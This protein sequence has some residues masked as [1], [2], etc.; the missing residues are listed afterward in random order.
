MDNFKIIIEKIQHIKYL[1]Y[2]I[3]LTKNSIHCIVGKNGIGKTTLVKAIQNLKLADTFDKTSS[4]YIFNDNSEITYIIDSNK[5]NYSYN[6]KTNIFD[7]KDIIDKDIKDNLYVELPIPYGD[8][9]Q[10]F[11][12]CGE[13][14]AD[15]RNKIIEGKYTKPTKLIQ[16]LHNIYKDDRF[17]NLK[18]VSIKKYKYYFILLDDNYY[19]RED[20]LSSG[21]YFLINIFKLIEN[22]C[23]LILIDELDISLDASA[24]VEL[25]SQLRE[26]AIEYKVNIIFTTHSLA[27]MKKMNSDELYY[28]DKVDDKIIIEK[29]SYNFI[30]SLLFQFEGFEKCIL[31][32]DEMLQNYMEYILKDE[33]IFHKFKIIYIGGAGNVIDIMD[34]NKNKLFFGDST[35]VISILDGDKKNT[36]N[37]NQ[38]VDIK[39]LPFDNIEKEL[40]LLYASGFLNY[41]IK[42]IKKV[43]DVKIAKKNNKGKVLRK[44]LIKNNYMSYPEIFKLVNNNITINHKISKVNTFKEIILKFLN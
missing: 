42:D 11:K 34:R 13:I 29:K 8:R 20:Y 1:E 17:H 9:F 37:Y 10:T 25:I 40:Y 44:A 24:Q 15:L 18:E 6:I 31:T 4:P 35:E 21:E 12:R 26:L 36:S 2:N 19:I 41:Y 43:E 3:D 39:F 14:D 30:K 22:R 16:L 5:Y 33:N 38:R 28:M 32:E 23:K 27:I 7:S